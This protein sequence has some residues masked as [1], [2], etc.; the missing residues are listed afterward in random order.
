MR[1][2]Q[3]GREDVAGKRQ[4]VTALF[5]NLTA[6][7]AYFAIADSDAAAMGAEIY[8]SFSEGLDIADSEDAGSCA[9]G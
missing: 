7:T 2:P 5:T 3:P 4:T 1:E 8:N 9:R 6:S